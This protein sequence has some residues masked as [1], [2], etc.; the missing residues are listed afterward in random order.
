M[1]SVNSETCNSEG[2]QIEFGKNL[3]LKEGSDLT[4]VAVGPMLQT[5]LDA[6]IDLDV[7]VVYCTT[8]KPF[9]VSSILNESHKVVIVYICKMK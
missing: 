1:T 9:D 7:T 2:Y 4:V 6:T 8:V 3:T 5:V